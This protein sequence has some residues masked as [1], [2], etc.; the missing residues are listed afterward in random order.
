M[1]ILEKSAGRSRSTI[2]AMAKAIPPLAERRREDFALT[3]LSAMH[4]LKVDRAH[5][6]GLSLG[7]VIA[8]AI[9][10]LDPMRTAS[11]VLADSF[12]AHPQG[13][14]IYDRS[15]ANSNDLRSMA[16]ARVDALLAQ[17]AD[18]KVR[19]EVIE[20]MAKISPDAY[21]VGSEAVWLADQRQ[22]AE[23]ILVP[24]MVLVGEKDIITPPEL[25]EQLAALIKGARFEIIPDAGHIANLE[26]PDAF[27]RA[28]EEFLVRV[29]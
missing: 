22:R 17:P 28:V 26:R 3:I 18:E 14:A 9:N 13:Q 12:A 10:H 5:I 21:L 20:T 6:C 2:Q 25:S 24:T 19:T 8:I 7:G 4:E 23:A 27:N 11:L 16:N 1:N 15:V 29:D